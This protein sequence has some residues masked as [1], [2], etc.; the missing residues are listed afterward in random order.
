[1]LTS[2][3]NTVSFDVG[4]LW[5]QRRAGVSN[6]VVFTTAGTSNMN[7]VVQLVSTQSIALVALNTSNSGILS[8]DGRFAV[9]GNTIL[10]TNQSDLTENGVWTVGGNTARHH[11]V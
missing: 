5:R 11:W 4:N 10:L 6:D 3:A 8:I 2:N 7:M 1:M 9:E